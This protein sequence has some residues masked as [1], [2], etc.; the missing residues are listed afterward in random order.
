MLIISLIK[1]EEQQKEGNYPFLYFIYISQVF[2]TQHG[3]RWTVI[4]STI[5]NTVPGLTDPAV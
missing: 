3:L 5:Q 4:K 1:N 2:K